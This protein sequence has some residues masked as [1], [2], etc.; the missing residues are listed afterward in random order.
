VRDTSQRWLTAGQWL[1]VLGM[2]NIAVLGVIYAVY[3]G[4]VDHGEAA[5]SAMSW[6]MLEGVPV[7]H[8]MDAADRI[9]NLYGPLNFLWNAWPLALFGG[10]VLTSKIAAALAAALIAPVIWWRLRGWELRG[11]M[12]ALVGALLVLHLA[13]PVVIRPDNILTVVVGLTVLAVAWGERGG[14]WKATLLAGLLA[15]AAVNLKLNAALYVAPVLLLYVLSDWRRLPLLAV[16]GLI[17]LVAP[18][19]LPLFPLDAYLS[20]F[21][22][23]AGK[24]N[25]WR[26]VTGAWWRF[27][28]VFAV[29]PLFWALAGR[30]ALAAMGRAQWAYLGSYLVCV[31]LTMFPASKIGGGGHYFLPFLPLMADLCRR[32]G[33][34]PES[35]ARQRG[36]LVVAFVGVVLMAFQ[37]E[38]RFLKKLDWAEARVVTAEIEQILAD[39][40]DKRIQ[41]GVGGAVG[42]DNLSFRFYVW[43]NMP[44]YRGHPYTLDTGTVMEMTK[45]GVPLPAETLR[46]LETCH[47]QLWLVPKGEEPFS[48]WGYYF[49]HA[50]S[51][52]FRE[53]FAAHHVKV[54]SRDTFDLWECRP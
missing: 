6:K 27:F 43:R 21:G 25:T 40:A 20:W 45:L 44:V 47:T 30:P 1:A 41:M 15:G 26:G 49:Q 11:W 19:A 9:S 36:F 13:F 24:E 39:H 38:R 7:Y 34:P 33:S 12:V 32:A 22:G 5:I 16:C 54:E 51:D 14:G 3:P 29:P 42:T 50:Y 28:F 31:L 2:V 35:R 52:Q 18:F 46:R 48:L 53:T 4:Y 23:M 17:S 37:N 10:S 8:G